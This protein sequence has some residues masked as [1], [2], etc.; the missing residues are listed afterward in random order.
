MTHNTAGLDTVQ[1]QVLVSN[2]FLCS[3]L[4]ILYY[5]YFLTFPAEYSRYWKAE[6]KFTVAHLLFCLNRYTAII[7]YIP[8]IFFTFWP[9]SESVR[10]QIC[11]RMT[12]YDELL[13][14]GIQF[15]VGGISVLRTYALYE[16]SWKILV[17]LCSVGLAT[18]VYGLHSVLILRRFVFTLDDLP[19]TGCLL[20]ASGDM[21][22]GLSQ[23]WI[24]SL[25]FDTVVFLL[26]LIKALRTEREGSSILDIVMRDG[27][28]YFGV[29][30]IASISVI[31]SFRVF[32]PYLT[33]MTGTLTNILS[34]IM[35]SRLMLN[36]RDPKLL[37][38]NAFKAQRSMIISGELVFRCD[39]NASLDDLHGVDKLDLF[40]ANYDVR[41]L[42]EAE[43]CAHVSESV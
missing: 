36:L 6:R 43:K 42:Q 27:A 38:E 34:S 8:H 1:A 7:G 4:V 20:P 29:M 39:D 26:T 33:G 14:V 9:W 28:M 37:L 24:G 40:S 35:I 5:D 18:S 19:P 16:R 11:L 30:I 22:K 12:N 41:E 32:P 3:C 31:L 17:L 10:L 25:I 2:R 13:I 15:I 23:A 21:T